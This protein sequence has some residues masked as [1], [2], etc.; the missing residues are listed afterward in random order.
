MLVKKNRINGDRRGMKTKALIFIEDGSF[1]Y[2]N[3][4]IREANALVAGGWE[5]TVISPRY[6]GDPFRKTISRH[7]RAYYYPK[8]NA[9]G[10]AG[11]VIEH[12]ISLIMGFLLTFW[13]WLRHGFSVLHACNPT[14]ILWIV[15]LPYKAIGKRFVFDQHDLCPELYLSR[16]DGTE[17]S[18][19]YKVLMIL[20]KMSFRFSDV[21]IATNESYKKVAVERGGK[22]P[23]DVFVVRNGPDLNKFHAVPPPSGL[24]RKGEVLVGYLGNMNLQDGV[25]YLLQ[26]AQEIVIRR[27]RA[28][29]RF[30]L[31]GGGSHRQKL[32]ELSRSMGLEK[33]VTFTG[34]VPDDKMLGLLSACDI[35]VQPDPHNPLNDASTMNKVM[36][37]MALDKPVVAFDLKETRVSCGNAAVYA[38]ANDAVDLGEKILSLADDPLCAQGMARLGRERVEKYLSWDHS[39]PHLLAAYGHALNNSS[40]HVPAVAPTYTSSSPFLAEPPTDISNSLS[41]TSG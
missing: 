36:E 19:F 40:S 30:I 25:E 41:D 29:V 2:D 23:C 26:A 35:C 3:R 24:K 33:N 13:V 22:L 10:A 14:D 16:G 38:S 37:Y 1:T 11:H 31:V 8:P 4:V 5:V 32:A 9:Q 6:R 12:G 20:E 15:A 7:L 21:V 34:R 28:N 17:K 27:G 18:F 39:V